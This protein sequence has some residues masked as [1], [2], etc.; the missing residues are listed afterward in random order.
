MT[1][2][3]TR[4]TRSIE[5][6][7][8]IHFNELV[9]VLEFAPGQTQYHLRRLRRNERI[10]AEPLYGRTHYYTPAYTDWERGALALLHRETA[11]DIVLFLLEEG[12][13]APQTVANDLDIARS[14]LEWHL[15]HLGEQDVVEKHRNSQNRVTLVLSRPTKTVELFDDIEPSLSKQ[16]VDRF[17]RLVDRL[18]EE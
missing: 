10:V 18:L 15:D 2:S 6:R 1:D 9:R 13:S 16:M 3:Q 4:I 17:T 14:T 12:A 7:P 11:R 5:N 8:G